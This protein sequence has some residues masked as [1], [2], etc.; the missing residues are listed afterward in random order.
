MNLLLDTHVALWWVQNHSI[1][2]EAQAAILDRSNRVFIS[3]AVIW[4]L[5]TKRS[6]N[7]LTLEADPEREWDE[8]GFEPLPISAAHARRVA[9]LPLHHR[10]PFDRILVAQAVAESMTLVTRDR[11]FAQYDVA[12]IQA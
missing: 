8:I 1:S 3:A 7:K 2:S 5:A 6:V 12:K 4:E 11:L 10:D 9:T